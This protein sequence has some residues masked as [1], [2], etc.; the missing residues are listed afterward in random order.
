MT[1]TTFQERLLEELSLEE[2][3]SVGWL[4]DKVGIRDATNIANSDDFR[5]ALETKSPTEILDAIGNADEKLSNL[6]DIIKADPELASAFKNALVRDPTVLEGLKEI[7]SN[8][9]G[10][11]LS[12]AALEQ[13]LS[14]PIAG[15]I[16]RGKL[17]DALNH[18]ADTDAEFSHIIAMGNEASNL[19]NNDGMDFL[20]MILEGGG[21]MIRSI[22]ASLGLP[23]ELIDMIAEMVDKISGVVGV[24][25][26]KLDF[27][28]PS[29]QADASATTGN[30]IDFNSKFK[31]AMEGKDYTNVEHIRDAAVT[32]D[33][34]LADE[35]QGIQTDVA[36]T[37][38]FQQFAPM[39]AAEVQREM[40]EMYKDLANPEV[41][42]R[43]AVNGI[44][45]SAPVPGM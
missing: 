21:D 25:K 38:K 7:A 35:M 33:P 23:Q 42:T 18:V 2:A 45:A 4:L 15:E 28:T 19:A 20:D 36:L 16:A 14:H 32:A 29:F 30:V 5:E 24:I 43:E 9:S 40:A 12:I 44:G 37:E 3:S 31:D 17:T 26:E 34:E 41:T 1:D 13:G 22:G 39:P 11:G 27:D 6:T 8:E 10:E